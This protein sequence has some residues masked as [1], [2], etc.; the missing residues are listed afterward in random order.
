M[1]AVGEVGIPFQSVRVQI[2]A[3]P[4][5]AAN[6]LGTWVPAIHVGDPDGVCLLDSVGPAWSEPVDG[7]FS[8]S[9]LP[10]K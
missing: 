9:F 6:G 3:T 1:G 5:P 2:S 7:R 10:S 4:V 8:L